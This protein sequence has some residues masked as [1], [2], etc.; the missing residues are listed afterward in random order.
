MY[1]QDLMGY[2]PRREQPFPPKLKPVYERLI[3]LAHENGRVAV[4]NQRLSQECS[5]LEGKVDEL[6]EKLKETKERA[7]QFERYWGNELEKVEAL[8]AKL[9]KKRSK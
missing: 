8:E 3:L 4:E 9:N 2:E 5:R 7:D 1:P 6:R